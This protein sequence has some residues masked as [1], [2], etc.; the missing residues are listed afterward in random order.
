MELDDSF[1]NPADYEIKPSD[2]ILIAGKIEQEFSGLEI[3][4]YEDET[5]NLIIHSDIILNS[6][7]I[8]L[9]WLGADLSQI[10]ANVAKRG[11]LA[12][13][14]MM[15]PAIE[16]W[17]MDLADPVEPLVSLGGDLGHKDSVTGLHLHHSRIN[18]LVS[19]SVDKSVKI[20]DVQ[21][22]QALVT[23]TD[24]ND[25]I[26]NVFWGVKEESLITALSGD[27]YLN[28]FDIRS[29]EKNKKFKLVDNIENFCQN[30]NKPEIFYLTSE[31]GE[32]MI[33]DFKAG[34][35]NK[36]SIMKVHEESAT[37]VVCSVNNHVITNSLD[38]KIKIF[39]GDNLKLVK[40]YDTKAGNLFGSD[41]H[42]ENPYL[43]SCGSSI[44]EVV[45][46]DFN[47]N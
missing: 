41:L 47:K 39:D 30:P 8:C 22:G 26:Q 13:V 14:G 44:G 38:S 12:I 3:Y 18:L 36:D 43:F 16:I 1:E 45:I 9:E 5:Q 17:D 40:E 21:T 31:K 23:N 15:T 46:W 2:N 29:Q 7:P 6:F 24:F 35:I 32:L 4:I 19:S 20:W 10:E 25:K 42:P 34:K 37:S 11:N 28:F 33:F 27:S